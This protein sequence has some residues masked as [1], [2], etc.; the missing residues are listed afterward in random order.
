VTAPADL[1]EVRAALAMAEQATPG[2]W[3]TF[4]RWPNLA[5]VSGSDRPRI[6][7]SLAS[8][9]DAVDDTPKDAAAIVAL[10]N[11]A[12][13]IAAAVEELERLRAETARQRE[14]IRAGADAVRSANASTTE[15]GCRLDDAGERIAALERQVCRLVSG[16]EIDGDRLCQHH[17]A[18]VAALALLSDERAAHA[19]TSR[20]LDALLTALGAQVTPGGQTLESCHARRVA[21]GMRRARREVP[22]DFEAAIA[23]LVAAARDATNYELDRATVADHLTAERFVKESVANLRASIAAEIDRAR[24]EGRGES[25]AAPAT[26]GDFV[27][28]Y[29]DPIAPSVWIGQEKPTHKIR[30]LRAG[31]VRSW[32]SGG[33]WDAWGTAMMRV[34]FGLPARLIT[35]VAEAEADPSSR[36][37]IDRPPVCSTCNDTHA[38]TLGDRTVMCTRCPTPCQSCRAGGVGPFCG[39]TPCTCECHAKIGGGS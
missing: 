30:Q 37:P 26:V 27:I 7:A 31:R 24:A 8:A 3:R 28:E 39:S 15:I 17:G 38:M 5:V 34:D 4:G 29:A 16:Q 22:A 10:R 35:D 18:D 9:S 36:W 12:P 25:P 32:S 33:G 2:P 13:A 23:S 1:A 21:D 6:V 20:D 14:T 19:E 11:A